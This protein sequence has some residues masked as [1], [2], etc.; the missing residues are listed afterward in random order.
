VA[1]DEF[2]SGDDGEVNHM[3]PSLVRDLR[4]VAVRLCAHYIAID[5]WGRAYAWA[6]LS[7]ALWRETSSMGR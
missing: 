6:E 7:W 1:A 5:D 3:D 4:D 2:A